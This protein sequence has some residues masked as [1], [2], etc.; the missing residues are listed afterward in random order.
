MLYVD[1]PTAAELKSLASHR[2]DLCVSIY[3]PTTPVTQ[4]TAADRI[5]LKNLGRQAIR[6][7]TEAEADKRRV[8]ALS[9]HID[10]LIDDD[11]FWRFQAH[12]LA[13]LATPDHVHTF[14]VPSAL[15]PVAVV[16]DRFHLK[17]LL[18]AA[19]FP[20][21]GYVLALAEGA[22][23]LVEVSADLP[24]TA[25]KVQGMPKDAASAV[26]KATLNDRSP[27]G[28]IQGSEGQKVRLR[29]YARKV[30]AALREMLAGSE[31]P[32][33]LAATE[34]LA[35]IYRSVNTYPH[36]AQATMSG[37]PDRLTDAQLAEQARAVLDDIYREEIAAWATLF[38]T[39]EN[40]GRAT[41][42]LGS[43]ARAA[44]MGAVDTMLVDID[45]VVPGTV[46]D[47]AG[48]VTIADEPGASSYG[49]VDEIAR[50][51]LLSGGRV[52]GVRNDDIPGEKPLAAI[53]R[54]PV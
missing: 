34:P 4:E 9:E 42:D 13:V 22:V 41:T 52:L 10:D 14:R 3:L 8:A 2:D 24:A 33:I 6:E 32:L 12:S 21:S 44:T 26:G 7:L 50:R 30:D 25:A 46:D 36:L 37:S 39:R 19:T 28:R 20:N 29:Q 31:V 35:S 48:T 11:E 38:A 17:P 16:S 53:L 18:R 43:A 5:A 47:V 27:S 23:R 45:A 54:Y 15:S 51:V 40:Q 1:I 49:V